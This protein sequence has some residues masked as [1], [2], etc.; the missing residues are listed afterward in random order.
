MPSYEFQCK[1]CE[2]VYAELAD[3]DP[4]GKYKGVKCPECGSKRK[5]QM[6]TS[7]WVKFADP[8]SSSRWD[9]WSYRR[10][11]TSEEASECRR[12]AQ[13]ASHVGPDPYQAAAQVEADLNNDS[14]YGEVK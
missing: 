13:E 7:C 10:G 11:K 9:N 12:K 6:M 4:S 3:H 5:S 14:L 8:R 1:K 2:V